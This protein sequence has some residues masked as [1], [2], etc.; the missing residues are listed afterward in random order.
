MDTTIYTVSYTYRSMMGNLPATLS[1]EATVQGDE[2]VK[3]LRV[4]LKEQGAMDITA[5]EY[6]APDFLQTMRRL[7]REFSQFPVRTTA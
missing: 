6:Q 4:W 7:K 2:E 3:D 5:R 1:G